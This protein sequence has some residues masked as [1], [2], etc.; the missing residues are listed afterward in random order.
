[1]KLQTII[2]PGDI[3][4]HLTFTLARRDMKSLIECVLLCSSLVTRL[5]NS[6]PPPT[7]PPIIR[8]SSTLSLGEGASKTQRL[9]VYLP[10]KPQEVQ[11][12]SIHRGQFHSPIS[13]LVVIKPGSHCKAP[14]NKVTEEREELKASLATA[15]DISSAHL[16]VNR[17]VKGEFPPY[18]FLRL[19]SGF[20]KT[21]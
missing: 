3:L 9:H 17:Y 4:Q 1:M 20:Y 21:L 2:D 5:I 6:T 16:E 14:K 7:N 19:T 11:T 12:R 18:G 13:Y 10:E 8:P 15:H